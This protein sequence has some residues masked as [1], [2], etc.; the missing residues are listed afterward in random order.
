M[1]H[2]STTTVGILTFTG[3]RERD[4][5]VG[6]VPLLYIVYKSALVNLFLENQPNRIHGNIL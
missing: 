2:P 4:V 6:S 1:C 3:T 5:Q